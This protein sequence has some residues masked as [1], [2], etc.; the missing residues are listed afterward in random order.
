MFLLIL[1]AICVD[2]S[3]YRLVDLLL[4]LWQFKYSCFAYIALLDSTWFT[5]HLNYWH[6]IAH[7]FR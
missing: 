1:V 7:R 2:I 6:L 5:V 3:V 4:C